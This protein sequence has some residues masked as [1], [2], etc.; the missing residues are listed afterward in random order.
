MSAMVKYDWSEEELATRRKRSIAIGIALGV[1]ALLFFV[2]TIVKL[3]GNM[4]GA[5][6]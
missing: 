4:A 6:G 5:G 2:T 3:T 1:V